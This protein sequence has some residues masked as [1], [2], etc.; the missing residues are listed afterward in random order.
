MLAFSFLI[1]AW[2]VLLAIFLWDLIQH[3]ADKVWMFIIIP[4]TLAL[5]V[6]TY[7]TVQSMLGYPTERVKEGK[8]IIIS[9]AVKE[10]DWIFYWVGY[11]GDD[12]PIAYRFPY[13]EQ[14]HEKQEE[15]QGRQEAGEVIQGELT[16]QTDDDTS[17]KSRLGQIEFYTFDVSR[18]IPK[19]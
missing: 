7:F 18:A 4:A 8:F 11:P 13:T 6:T 14:D 10:P 2:L 19:D 17:S 1:V 9:S 5:T 15:I 12:E 16:D 3:G